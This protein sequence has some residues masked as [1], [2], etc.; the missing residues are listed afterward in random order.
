MALVSRIVIAACA[1]LAFGMPLRAEDAF[2][3]DSDLVAAVMP[4]V[5]NIYNRHVVT[6][7]GGSS[8][9]GAPLIQ[10]ELGAGFIV[11]ASGIIITNRHVI[12]G[13]YALFVT[14]SDGSEW[15]ATLVGKALTFDI[16]LVKISVGRPL[17]VAK[18]GDSEK[19][20]IGNRVVAIGNPEGFEGSASAGIV[21]AFHRNVGLSAY[22]DLIQV[23]AAINKGNSGGPLFNMNGEVV[24]INQAIYSVNSGGSVGIGFSIPINEAKFLVDNVRT[25]GSSHIGYFGLK[26]QN[27]TASMAFAMGVPEG[28]VIVADLVANGPA[29][30]AG[31][32]IGDIVVSFNG[33]RV[34]DFQSLNRLVARAVEQT[35]PVTVL[36]NGVPTKLSVA[37]VEWPRELWASGL[38]TSPKITTLADLGLTFASD[39]AAEPVVASVVE[40]SIAWTAGFRQGDHVKRVELQATPTMAVLT[41]IFQDLKASDRINAVVLLDGPDNGQRWVDLSVRE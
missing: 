26:G 12:E 34:S 9:P 24:G 10:D 2:K 18:I 5:V 6:M 31:L 32:Q 15:P 33:E 20:R 27:F 16:A 1:C 38:A 30:K 41:K 4:T 7:D 29:A 8:T 23:D 19:L 40:K 36:R 17:P 3:S 25:F 13:A 11:D 35:V 37:I 22:D 39:Q 14:L 21:S 28:G